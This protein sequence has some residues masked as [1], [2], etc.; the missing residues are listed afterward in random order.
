MY[1]YNLSHKAMDRKFI[2][3]A[4]VTEFLPHLMCNER[5]LVPKLLS[6]YSQV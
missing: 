5:G 6:L 2:S 1:N 3:K 4:I